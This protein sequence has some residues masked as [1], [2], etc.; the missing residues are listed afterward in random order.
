MRLVNWNI[1]RRSPHTWQAAS[2]V[3]EITGLAPDIICLTEAHTAS[4]DELG[5]HTI[6]HAGYRSGKK[7][8]GERLVLLWSRTRWTPIPV[9]DD[10]ARS[11]GIV[12]GGTEIKGEECLIIGLCIPYH[13]ARLDHE[14]RT[15]PWKHHQTFLKRLAPWLAGLPADLPIVIAGD[16]NRRVP[17][18]WGP[19]VAYE[20]LEAAFSPFDLVTSGPLAP[21]DEHT[22][23]HVAVSAHWQA[24]GVQARSRFE[25]DG[26]ARSDHFGVVVDLERA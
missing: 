16:Y 2:L 18:N 21:L 1:E 10:L 12:A 23:D 7:K 26:R 20:L 4:L 3:S 19:I 22:I 25:V 14:T 11:G 24:T 5:G 9:P 17:R 13:M 15:A 6:D 8:P